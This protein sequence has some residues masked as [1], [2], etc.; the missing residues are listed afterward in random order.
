MWPHIFIYNMIHKLTTYILEHVCNVYPFVTNLLTSQIRYMY[1]CVPVIIFFGAD[2]C[3]C[4]LC[5]FVNFSKYVTIVYQCWYS[6][7]TSTFYVVTK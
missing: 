2:P 1:H 4:T 3:T 7:H 6:M 5:Y